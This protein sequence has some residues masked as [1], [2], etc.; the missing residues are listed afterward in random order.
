MSKLCYCC[1]ELFDKG[2]SLKCK[3]MNRQC[4]ICQ[5]VCHLSK[6]CRN[7]GTKQVVLF[8]KKE[9]RTLKGAWPKN[10]GL[11]S[12]QDASQPWNS[13]STTLSVRRNLNSSSILC[14]LHPL[15]T[16]IVS[17]QNLLIKCD[18]SQKQSH[19]IRAYF[20]KIYKSL[21]SKLSNAWKLVWIKSRERRY[22]LRNWKTNSTTREP[23]TELWRRK[24]VK[25]TQKS[26]NWKQ[27]FNLLQIVLRL[28]SVSCILFSYRHRY[29]AFKLLNRRKA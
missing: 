2:H 15:L 27:L 24:S 10:N 28:K 16:I 20:L 23:R 6:Q 21:E 7:S 26:I 11:N 4:F 19:L 9:V 17:G 25:W 22:W 12:N 3:A 14:V 29:S 13:P 1:G 8:K 5:R 18:H